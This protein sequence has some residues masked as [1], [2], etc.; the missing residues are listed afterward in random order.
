MIAF[1]V[2]MACWAAVIALLFWREFTIADLRE[3]RG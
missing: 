3:G 2:S 1:L